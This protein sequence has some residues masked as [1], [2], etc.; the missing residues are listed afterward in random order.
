MTDEEAIKNLTAYAFFMYDTFPEGVATAFDMAIQSLK[1]HTEAS[2][3]G[4][5]IENKRYSRKGKRFF[6]CS[7]CHYGENGEVMVEVPKI[8]NFCPNC[9]VK[10]KGGKEK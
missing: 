8:P 3:T 5:W 1:N 6:D 7:V 2:V 9:G 10:M 4:E